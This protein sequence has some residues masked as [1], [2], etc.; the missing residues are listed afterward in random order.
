MF[1]SKLV[2]VSITAV[3]LLCCQVQATQTTSHWNVSGDGLWG[4]AG[5]WDPTGVPNNNTFDVVIDPEGDLL[6]YEEVEV[7]LQ[8]NYTI[9]KLDCSGQVDL[10]SWGGWC[11]LTLDH[12][13][14]LRN[15][16]Y[17]EI[18]WI[19]I[20]GNVNNLDSA[21]LELCDMDI[22]GNLYNEVG[23]TIGVEY[24]AWVDKLEGAA[25]TGK[26]ENYG[27]IE[28]YPMGQL[29]V[30][31]GFLNYNSGTILMHGGV[32]A[33][34]EQVLDNRGLIAGFGI[35]YGEQGVENSGQIIASSGSLVVVSEGSLTNTG[36]L[37]NE[38][39]ASLQIKPDLHFELPSYVENYGRIEVNAGG[40]VAF[41]WETYLVNES[42]G[43]IELR[44]GTLAA[45]NITQSAGATFEGGGT[46]A[47]RNLLI[48]SSA[49]I[50]LTGPTI[51][52][53]DVNIVSGGTLMIRASQT[54]I[55]GH[56]T[57]NGTIVLAGGTVIFRGGYSGSGKVIDAEHPGGI[58]I[59]NDDDGTSSTGTWNVSNAPGFYGTNSQYNWQEGGASY[60]FEA[61]ALGAR[62]V[63]LWWNASG[64]RSTN[65]S[66][67]IYNGGDLLDTVT[68]NQQ[69]NG[70]QWNAL[71]YYTFTDEAEVRIVSAG[72]NATIADAVR[73]G[74]A[75]EIVI[76]N[77]DE[78]TSSFGT[79]KLSGAPGFY[80]ENSRYIW[81]QAGA[82]YSFEAPISGVYEV[83]LWWNAGS[84][85]STN[86][87][88]EIYDGGTLLNTVTG[89]NQQING[90]KWNVLGSIGYYPFNYG[91][92]VKIISPGS[93]A[94]IADAVKFTP[95]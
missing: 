28:I 29:G 4:T 55:G 43:T 76:D 16:G 23:A 17:L 44:G 70:G 25:G 24:E 84:N 41:N 33:A 56:T 35:V 6:Y 62:E 8:N 88:V 85:R 48:E 58:I 32:C 75:N 21:T 72:S 7:G 12:E 50:E 46:I 22:E 49:E 66:V 38:P 87:S 13:D 20:I 86:V 89:I 95:L 73:F 45:E 82:S 27:T 81:A 93:G 40:G 34:D 30:E 5:N 63:S 3:F 26:L 78:G 65:V 52:V 91:A 61:W 80:G 39:L 47:C 60:S 68:V 64:N 83:S 1:R 94:T 92:K 18:E 77:D 71:G 90:G 14:G 11:E 19:D 2:L 9:N 57:N 31:G 54:F 79:W 51:I 59:D 37:R 10:E 74:P 15:F 42:G 53:R 36:L 67:G 69:I